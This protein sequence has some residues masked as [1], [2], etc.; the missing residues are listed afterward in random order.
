[1]QKMRRSGCRH[2]LDGQDQADIA[3]DM[4][5]S[6]E[7]DWRLAVACITVPDLHARAYACPV[8]YVHEPSDVHHGRVI[9]T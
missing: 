1:M 9:L 7:V 4:L 2:E 3:G 5:I 8:C 6:S